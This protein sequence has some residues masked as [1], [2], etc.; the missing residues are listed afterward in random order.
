MSIFTRLPW[1]SQV[2]I[3]NLPSME[4]SAWLMPAHSGHVERALQLPSSA[5]RGSRVACS[6]SATTI[7]D[8][9]SGVKYM[10]YGSSTAI[11]APGLPVFGSIGVRRAVGAALGVVGDPQRLEV[12][13]RHD[14]LR[15]DARRERVDHLHGRGVDHRHRVRTRGSARRPAASAPLAAALSLPAASRCRGSTGP[16]RPGMPGIVSIFFG[17]GRGAA[18]W[19]RCCRRWCPGGGGRRGLAGA[20]AVAHATARSAMAVD[21]DDEAT[22]PAA[23]RSCRASGGTG[24]AR[25]QRDTCGTAAGNPDATR[26][27]PEG[28]GHRPSG[29]PGRRSRAATRVEHQRAGSAVRASRCRGRRRRRRPARSR[30]SR[31]RPAMWVRRSADRGARRRTRRLGARCLGELVQR[32]PRRAGSARSRRP[33]AAPSRRPGRIHRCSWISP[34]STT[35]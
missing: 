1:N 25:R 26:P 3:A 15:V 6:A 12:P 9:P 7:A 21:D 17:A 27:D 33:R 13:R 22:G 10:L 34:S 32:H 18:P 30:R 23:G 2:K 16:A 28:S 19:R 20:A 31:R 29:Q 5:G 4:K 14:V 24:R 35:T 8:L 11:D